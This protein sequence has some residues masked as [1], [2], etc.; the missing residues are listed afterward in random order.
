MKNHKVRLFYIL[1]SIG[2]STLAYL[3][4]GD[5]LDANS[6]ALD[7]FSYIGTIATLIG[8][9]IAIFEVIHSVHISNSIKDEA[10]AILNKVK[11]VENAST[12]S[13]CLAAIDEVNGNIASNDF[14]SALKS[15]QYFRKL[16]V[17]V[18]PDLDLNDGNSLGKLGELE[19]ELS[20]A[21]HTTAQAPLNKKQKHEMSKKVLIVKQNVERFNPARGT[22]NVTG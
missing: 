17:K 16:T 10:S 9:V 18:L 7:K 5:F 11:S 2:I 13:D 20:A 21:T 14:R 1:I 3:Y 12:V 8:L 4:Q 19:L 6:S 15:F 22:E